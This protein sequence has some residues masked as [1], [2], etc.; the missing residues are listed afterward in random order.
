MRTTLKSEELFEGFTLL[1]L[2]ALQAKTFLEAD[3]PEMILLALLT[4][5]EGEQSQ[6]VLRSIIERLQAKS[7]PTELKKYL[8]QLLL[9][10]RIRQLEGLTFKMI[11]NMPIDYK[12]EDSLL[13]KKGEEKGMEKGEKKGKQKILTALKCL[14][15][16]KSH[17]ETALVSGLTLEEVK[18]LDAV[19]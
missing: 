14:K 15:E 18:A 13:F 11:E 9:L 8:Q 10:S 2:Q 4:D 1:S 16:G 12:I 5:Y 6:Q 17:K 19:N 3:A 7:N